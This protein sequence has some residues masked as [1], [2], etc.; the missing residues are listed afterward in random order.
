MKVLVKNFWFWFATWLLL[1]IFIGFSWRNPELFVLVAV[2]LSGVIIVGDRRKNDLV[3]F[4]ATGLGAPIL[5]TIAVHSGAW[6]Y[7]NGVIFGWP[8]W[9]PFAYALSALLFRRIIDSLVVL[10]K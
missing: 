10:K 9:L 8:I 1:C 3:W 5:D 6:S 7:P 2:G 4:L